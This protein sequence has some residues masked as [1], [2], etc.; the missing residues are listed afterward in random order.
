MIGCLMIGGSSER[1]KTPKAL[2]LRGKTTLSLYLFR[3]MEDLL[4]A[5]PVLVGNGPIDPALATTT[6]IEDLEP[7]AGPLSGLVG[8]FRALPG[9]D[10]LVLATDLYAMERDALQWL[11][12]RASDTGK[13][14]IWP[15]FANQKYGEPLAGIY[16]SDCA[17]IL[18][19]A[20]AHGFRGLIRAVP[21]TQ[22]YQ[23]LIPPHL[24]LMFS[25]PN[26]PEELEALRKKMVGS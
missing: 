20:W 15:G 11:L 17:P 18:E 3:L 26:T 10:F 23:P 2:I 6:K 21:N 1:M 24:K 25:N 4:G 19:S 7:G 9:N 12:E 5:P 22:K 14:F 8:L 13:P 16:R